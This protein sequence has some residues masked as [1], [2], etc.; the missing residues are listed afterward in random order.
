MRKN[1]LYKRLEKM[2]LRHCWIK[3]G[4]KCAV[5]EHLGISWRAVRYKFKQYGLDEELGCSYK[6]KTEDKSDEYWQKRNF[7]N[8]KKKWGIK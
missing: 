4:N 6:F 5:A 3:Y 7:Y 8:D 2:L 1:S